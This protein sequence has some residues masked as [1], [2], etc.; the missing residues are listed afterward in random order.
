[1]SSTV[2]ANGAEVVMLK[3]A[4]TEGTV[5]DEARIWVKVN[6]KLGQVRFTLASP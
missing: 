5:E 1:M 4:V 3:V 6:P 2:T